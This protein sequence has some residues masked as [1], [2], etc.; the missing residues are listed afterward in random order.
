M[1]TGLGEG[2]LNIL[3]IR[4]IDFFEEHQDTTP[5][6]IFEFLEERISFFEAKLKQ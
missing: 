4:W 3:G 2:P 6:D 1:C 5:Q